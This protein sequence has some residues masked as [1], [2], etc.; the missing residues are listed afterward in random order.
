[1]D[2]EKGEEAH[3]MA[4]VSDKYKPTHSS[5]FLP[6]LTERLFGDMVRITS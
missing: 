6:F 2:P 1:M 4:L 3:S 5:S